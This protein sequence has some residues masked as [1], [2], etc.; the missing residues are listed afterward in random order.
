M[1]G[2]VKPNANELLVK[3]YE[4]YRALYCGICHSMKKNTGSLSRITLTYDSVFLA[5]VR[6]LYSDNIEFKL[7]KKRCIAHPLKKKNVLK[8]NEAISYTAR[9]FAILSYYKVKDDVCDEK[10]FKSL[11]GRSLCP[12]LKGAKRRA[13]ILELE[14][15]I[16]DKLS[17]IRT[18]ELSSSSDI[19]GGANLFG[20][21]LGAVFSYGFSGDDKTV[22]Y[23]CGYHL[24]R[25]I[26]CAD[27]AEDYDKDRASGAYNPY[28][29][30]Y[31]K[32]DLTK[33]NKQTIY[34][35]LVLICK[36]IEAAV[37]LMPVPDGRDGIM[38]IIR[39]VV[40]LGLTKR[41]EFLKNETEEI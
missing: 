3:E 39:N 1:F 18:L 36:R 38:Q 22:L 33:E 12:I 11:P 16:R 24:G 15:I 34:T 28:V 8:D 13:D 40:Y 41:I 35:A 7:E 17:L 20:E 14:D 32:K 6:M 29:I 30:L 19:D 2:Y 26:Y 31:D 9:V 23:E 37:D 27:A 4:F 25:F 5:L 21:L 10:F